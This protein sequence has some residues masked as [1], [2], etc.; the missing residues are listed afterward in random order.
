VLDM[1]SQRMLLYAKMTL[2]TGPIRLARFL[3]GGREESSSL[4]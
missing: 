3:V 4:V 2:L 1:G